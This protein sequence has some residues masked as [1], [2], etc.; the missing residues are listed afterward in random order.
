MILLLLPFAWADDPPPADPAP[1]PAPSSD[2]A[3]APAPAPAPEPAP[4]PAPAAEE[5]PPPEDDGATSREGEIVVEA[6]R[7]APTVSEQTLDREKVLQTPG[8]FEDPVRLVQSLPGVAATPEYSPTA[9]D[10]AIRGADPRESRYFLDGIELPYLYHFNGYSSVFHTRILDTLTLLPS[11][12]SAQYG[13]AT[14]GIVEARSVWSPPDRAHGSLN[15]NMVMSGASAEVPIGDQWT[16][17]ASARRSYLDLFSASDEQ[18]SVF[19]VFWD[20]FARAEYSPSS[21]TKWGLL[22]FGAGD[23]YTRY[24]GEPSQL[25]PYEQQVNPDFS[26]ATSFHVAG[27]VHHHLLGTTTADGSL[28]WTGSWMDGTL[29]SAGQH[30]ADQRIQ[31]REDVVALFGSRFSLATGADAIADDVS[32]SV[33]TD[34]EWP[35][36]ARE[37]DLLSRGIDGSAST[38]RLRAGGY[39]EGRVNLGPVRVVP[40]VRVDGDTLTA[41]VV[42]DPRLNVRWQVAPDTRIRLAAGLYHQ[43]PAADLLLAPFGDPTIGPSSS[44]QA[45]AAF[46][47]VI[48]HRLELTVEGYGSR[49]ENLVVIDPGEAPRGGADGIAYG[50]ELDSRYRIRDKFFASLTLSAGRSER[51]G[52]LSDYDQPYTLNF[53]ASWNF[54]PGWNAGLRYRL[55]AGLPY[56]PIEDGRYEAASDSYA[57]MYGVINSE[58]LPTYMKIDG[59][60]E[61]GFHVWRGKVTAYAELWYVPDFANTMY[62]AWSYDYDHVEDVRGP[63]FVP[64]L[65]IRG[66]I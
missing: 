28:T 51:D 62:L 22:A 54:L 64:L 43:F 26:Y 25:D 11:T 49:G 35:E 20:Y 31:A 33:T 1:A 8:T 7:D 61:K 9:G 38:W 66:E 50:V 52:H 47:T 5:A 29:P 44:W 60:L 10:L 48:A 65:G 53:I 2:P 36:V 12:F 17:R 6:R 19:P 15:L 23:S 34:R 3:P 59:H 63:S 56:T 45:A 58:R 55:A 42:P 30:V 40:G 39:A 4:A 32:I 27:L 37:A 46:E 18:Y 57:P 21:D 24:A 14:G 16:L 13:D 41:A